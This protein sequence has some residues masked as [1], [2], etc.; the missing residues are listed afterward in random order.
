MWAGGEGFT[1]NIIFIAHSK[2]MLVFI[3]NW[4]NT[5]GFI[6]S[7]LAFCLGQTT[8]GVETAQHNPGICY[9]FF[10]FNNT[11][12]KLNRF[13]AMNLILMKYESPEEFQEIDCLRKDP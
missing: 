6:A 7:G 5:G 9:I 1:L 8:Q 13:L 4:A 12:R 2:L 3:P 10:C 11:I